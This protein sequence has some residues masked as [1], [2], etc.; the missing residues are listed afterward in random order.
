MNYFIDD[1]QSRL[2]IMPNNTEGS[3]TFAIAEQEPEMTTL[4]KV[5]FNDVEAIKEMLTDFIY[6]YERA[7]KEGPP[8][9]TVK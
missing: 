6:D 1:K 5:E 3:V 9:L 4:V 8:T 2:E 7:L